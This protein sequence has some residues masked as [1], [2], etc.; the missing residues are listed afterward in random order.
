MPGAWPPTTFDL[1]G[2]LMSLYRWVAALLQTRPLAARWLSS[3]SRRQPKC[4]PQLEWLETRLCPV[5]RIDSGP[6]LSVLQFAPDAGVTLTTATLTT[7]LFPPHDNNYHDVG[8]SKAF[9]ADGSP[10]R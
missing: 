1:E 7:S 3:K 6:T 10:V 9:V 2:F 8:F 4:L 5:G